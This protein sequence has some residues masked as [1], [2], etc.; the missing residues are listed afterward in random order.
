[1]VTYG[2]LEVVNNVAIVTELP[3]GKCP[4]GYS[5]FLKLLIDSGEIT[6]FEDNCNEFEQT[7]MFKIYGHKNPTLD[8]LKLIKSVGLGNIVFLDNDNR[9]HKYGDIQIALEEWYKLR[10]PYYEKR[11]LHKLQELKEQMVQYE[12]KIR[13]YQM[14]L[15]GQIDIRKKKSEILAIL[16]SVGIPPKVYTDCKLSHIS[17][18]ELEEFQKDVE[19][20]K[21][22]I[23][24]YETNKAEKL[25]LMD[26]DNFEKECKKY[27]K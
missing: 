8:T 11:R 4:F 5:N 14:V 17:V 13:F 10:L 20:C 2:K 18:E 24:F 7:I 23:L 27:V 22:E 21:T 6:H 16:T 1:M 12:Y 3:I 26:L 15:S 19:K 9:P 25:W